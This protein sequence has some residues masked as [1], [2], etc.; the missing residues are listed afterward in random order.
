MLPMAGVMLA[1]VVGVSA[2][3][4]YLSARRTRIQIEEQLRDVCRTLAEESR[5]PLTDSV[6]RQ[7]RGLSGAEFV[8]LD[9][10]GQVVS[11]SGQW[12]DSTLVAGLGEPRRWEEL[13]LGRPRPVAGRRYFPTLVSLPRREV[14]PGA[15]ALCILYPEQSYALALRHA[16]YPPLAVGGVALGVVVLLAILLASGVSRPMIRFQEQVERI[17]QGDFRPIPLAGRDDELRD[18]G[19]SINRMAQM[20]ARYEEEVRR[21]EQLRTL[22]QLSSGLAHQL[23]NAVTGCGMAL[24][25]HRRECHTAADAETLEVATRQLKL[26]E[27]YVQRFLSL[28][29]RQQRPHARVDLTAVVE[30][31]LPLIRPMARHF[32]VQLDWQPPAEPLAVLGDGEELEQLLINLLTN[33][34]EAAAPS[35]T[36]ADAAPVRRVVVRLAPIDHRAVA[37]EVWDSGPGP[38]PA[39]RHRVFEPFVSEKPDGTGLGLPVARAIAEQ[40]GG[41]IRWERREQMTRFVVEIPLLHTES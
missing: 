39:V 13:A 16:I 41:E 9:G 5:F 28:G 34:V 8:L 10:T 26:M 21:R 18:L 23:R 25:L 40:H 35:G 38:A 31:V 22:D 33:A 15:T 37:M 27:K 2:L 17:A 20:L 30:S 24:D 3:T 36:A 14:Q 1:V 6:L 4:A 7:M 32:D 19:Q 12:S 11:S 29:R